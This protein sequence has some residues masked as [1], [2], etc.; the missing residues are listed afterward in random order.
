[1]TC[2]KELIWMQNIQVH[3]WFVAYWGAN[4]CNNNIEGKE[5]KVG[6]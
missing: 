6:R 3:A 2:L 4:S 1:M 5:K